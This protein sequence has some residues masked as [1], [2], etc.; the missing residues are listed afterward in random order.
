MPIVER[1][2]LNLED[3]NLNPPFNQRVLDDIDLRRTG[4]A[5][6]R[7]RRTL[8]SVALLCAVLGIVLVQTLTPVYT[9][10]AQL[11]IGEEQLPILKL[12]QA[13]LKG[14]AND[15]LTLATEVNIIRSRKIAEKTILKLGLET[16]PE[17]NP[18][19]GLLSRLT[20]FASEQHYVP[21]PW[22]SKPPA[23]MHEET[24]T[25][26]R[27]NEVIDIV[28]DRLKVTND[29]KSRIITISF[30]STS[31]EL[32]T[33]IVNTVADFY[34]TSQLDAK[35]E[36][37]KRANSWLSD[38][39]AELKSKQLAADDAV[40][41]FRQEHGLLQGQAPGQPT[42]TIVNQQLSQVSTEATA[43]HTKWLEAQSR[44]I[45][46]QRSKGGNLGTLPE[47]L[48]SPVIQT[49]RSQETEAS[50]RLADLSAHFG[51]KHP[52]VIT[53]R[54][55]L[56]DIEARIRT[57]IAKVADG[58]RAEA[59]SQQDR[60]RRLNAML[61]EMK[62]NSSRSNVAEVQLQELER[63]AVANKTLYETLLQRFQ[64]TQ[65]GQGYQQP[66]TQ[67]VSAAAIPGSPSFPQKTVLILI[68]ALTG[69]VIGAF[70]ALLFEN[71]DVG[72]RSVEQVRELL[73][74]APLGMVPALTSPLKR[75]RP[76]REVLEQPMSAYSEAVRTVFANV[77]L[78]D[79]DD[80]P[81]TILVTSPLPGEGK[82]TFALS[83]A[84]T[85]ARENQRVLLIDCDLR[86]PTL[87]KLS[88][89]SS[90]PGLVD[91]LLDKVPFNDIVF[92]HQES[93]VSIITAGH[94]PAVP[95]NL[96][97]SKRFR[98]M[99]NQIREHYD[100]IILDSAPVL[101]I[102]DT[103]ALSA[104]ADKT[105]LL[106]QWAHTSRKV[107]A[108]A[109]EQLHRAGAQIAGAVLARVDV[110]SHAKDAF[111]DSILYTKRV[112]SYYR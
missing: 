1:P 58:L 47:V 29:G 106:V 25:E 65:T 49:L 17:F 14:D 36:A 70:L 48:Q 27:L 80:R 8:I 60:E 56:G 38:Q 13:L 77:L 46:L 20:T 24:E 69:L 84:Y 51:D 79:V 66:T 101:A 3:K 11:A 104:L 59:A 91:W 107:A 21:L 34:V 30:W 61:D 109:V 23:P 67:I 63:E 41:K 64:E 73:H 45:E 72:L 86:R 54:A 100:Y 35:L 75:N 15:T 88:G 37:T 105:L 108:A 10:T 110:Q 39:L 42:T 87:H 99:L 55:D 44:L 18:A 89:V 81:K 71:M 92:S 52:T 2:G 26:R 111:S 6:W 95:P 98:H 94:L 12:E 40:A 68:A 85:M 31:P 9:A 90:G 33:Q 43:A 19:P 74:V 103:S 32:A 50:R 83:L 62:A 57:E 28:L 16:L 7:W 4:R 93:S 97:G 112:T 5:L 53:A 96:L 102:A 22:L 76:E 82:S 78:S